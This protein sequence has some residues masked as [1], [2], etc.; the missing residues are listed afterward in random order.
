MLKLENDK[1][2]TDKAPMN[3]EQASEIAKIMGD[4]FI[5]VFGS[6]RAIQNNKSVKISKAIAKK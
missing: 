6:G 4:D 1:L 5:K 2:N 3:S